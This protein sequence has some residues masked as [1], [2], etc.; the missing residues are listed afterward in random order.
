MIDK[1][2]LVINLLIPD[3]FFRILYSISEKMESE[4]FPKN[5]GVSDLKCKK[6]NWKIRNS[7][8]NED[9]IAKIWLDSKLIDF[10]KKSPESLLQQ[11]R[12]VN[13]IK[14]F[15]KWFSRRV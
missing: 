15:S 7:K 13:L 1:S 2:R 12:N 3:D 5:I 9:S 6:Q 11:I 10:N 14:I 4:R 8:R